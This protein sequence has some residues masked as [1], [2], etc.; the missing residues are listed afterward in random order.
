M[1]IIMKN[2]VSLELGLRLVLIT[3]FAIDL[4]AISSRGML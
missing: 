3:K 1:A 2:G 4:T